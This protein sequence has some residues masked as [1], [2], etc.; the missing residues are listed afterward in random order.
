MVL[1]YARGPVVQPVSFQRVFIRRPLYKGNLIIPYATHRVSTDIGSSG[2]Q[3]NHAPCRLILFSMMEKPETRTREV[4][5]GEFADSPDSPSYALVPAQDR[6]VVHS[7]L[8]ASRPGGAAGI[9]RSILRCGQQD[10][11]GLSRKQEPVHSTRKQRRLML[12]R[13]NSSCKPRK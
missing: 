9:L 11:G 8:C 12:L 13:G 5:V 4:V 7:A 3:S 6:C 1:L 2:S 10:G